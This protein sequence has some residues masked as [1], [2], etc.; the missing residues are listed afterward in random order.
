MHRKVNGASQGE[1]GAASG[2]EPHPAL[3]VDLWRIVHAY[4][5]NR[6]LLKRKDLTPQMRTRVPALLAELEDQAR[7][8]GV[9]TYCGQWRD[10]PDREQGLAFGIS[11][12]RGLEPPK[13]TKRD[14]PIK[15]NDRAPGDQMSELEQLLA[16]SIE[17]ANDS[18]RR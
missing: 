9:W 1:A 12:T 5:N 3:S 14:K 16:A 7:A 18:T 2:S 17:Q 15:P 6:A 8:A 13:T 11:T 4:R 10:Y